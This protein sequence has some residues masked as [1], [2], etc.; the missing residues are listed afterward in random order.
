[1]LHIQVLEFQILHSSICIFH[2][3]IFRAMWRHRCQSVNDANKRDSTWSIIGAFDLNTSRNTR[4]GFLN[5][6]VR[7]QHAC[8]VIGSRTY[9]PIYEGF[10]RTKMADNSRRRRLGNILI[11][12]TLNI[13]AIE[14]NFR[15]ADI[16]QVLWI[17]LLICLRSRGIFKCIIE[18]NYF[19]KLARNYR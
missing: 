7:T 6:T 5:K 4:V 12:I 15:W 14:A 17:A 3:A 13:N 19:D 9:S 1:M 18:P 10:T 8:C 11:W 16:Y 2:S